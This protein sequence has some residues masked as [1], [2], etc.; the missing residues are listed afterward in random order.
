MAFLKN[1]S[2]I[3]NNYSKS[4]SNNTILLKP[5]ISVS[6]ISPLFFKPVIY[7]CQFLIEMVFKKIIIIAFL[8][9]ARQVGVIST[10]Q[11]ALLLD[12]WDFE[13][14]SFNIALAV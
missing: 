9:I 7:R 2:G 10:T 4:M 3:I 12:F 11:A 13:V 14:L 5:T 6:Y 1:N 8:N